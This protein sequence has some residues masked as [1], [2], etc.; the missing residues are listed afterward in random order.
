[1]RGLS[2]TV[3][4]LD[5]QENSRVSVVNGGLASDADDESLTNNVLEAEVLRAANSLNKIDV[6]VKGDLRVAAGGL[7]SIQIGSTIDA[8]SA[9]Q[10]FS[11]EYV[12]ERVTHQLHPQFL[13]RILA[14]RSGI[15]GT[16]NKKLVVPPGGV[17]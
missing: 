2:E 9:H 11:G 10:G 8:N 6:L 16:D 3:S 1:M 15:S 5:D 17:R 14:F 12:V 4:M 7:V 13:T